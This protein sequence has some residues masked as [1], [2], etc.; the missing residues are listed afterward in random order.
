MTSKRAGKPAVKQA[1]DAAL[2]APAPAFG[3]LSWVDRAYYRNENGL[4]KRSPKD[5]GADLWIASTFEVLAVTRD[6]TGSGWGLIVSFLDPDGRAHEVAIP[7]RELTA[8]GGDMRARLADGGLLMNSAKAAREAMVAYLGA[9]VPPQR[10]RCVPT[11][12]WHRIGGVRVFVTPGRVYGQAPERAV[13]QPADNVPDPFLQGGTLAAWRAEVAAPCV[14]NTR[15]LFA[16]SCAFAGPLLELLGE[17]G[18]GFNLRGQSRVGKSTALRVAASVWGGA[19]GKGAEGFVN[20]WR[21]TD[22]ALEAVAAARCDAFLCLDEMSQVDPKAIGEIAYMLAN[23]AGKIRANRSGL[24]RPVLRFRVLF[25]S[26]GET[27][28]AGMNAEAGRETKA[29]QEMRLI[30]VRAEAAA[31]MGLFETLHGSPTPGAFVERL[32]QATARLY[33]TAAPA[34]LEHVTGELGRGADAFEHALRARIDALCKTWTTYLGE[35]GG[36]VRSVASRFALVAAAGELASAAGITGWQMGLAVDACRICFDEWVADRGTLG[37]SEDMQAISRVAAFIGRHASSRFEEWGVPP[38]DANHPQAA[39]D[40]AAPPRG[41]PIVNRAGW[42]RWVV[43]IDGRGTWHYLLH[44]S[45][46]AEALGG[47][48]KESAY[49]ALIDAGFMLPGPGGKSSR[50]LSPP[51]VGKARPYEI[52]GAI[53]GSGHAD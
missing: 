52:I 10:A 21:A 41:R 13:F 5:D 19:A 16:V 33:G 36:Q 34:W 24:P 38:D 42:R 46:M 25:L 22:N 45:A 30:D 3:V 11:I 29:G 37:A 7:R 17:Q 50:S 26:T 31:A 12:G 51:G 48:H 43:G 27:G 9:C 44:P 49:R 23:G 53:M 14:G 4:Y 28:L 40:D 20:Q 15:L 35:V 8:D 6:E 2:P 39:F 1:V 47:L 18:G 32:A